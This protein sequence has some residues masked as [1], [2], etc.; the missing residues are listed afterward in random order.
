M[1]LAIEKQ[2]TRLQ[3]PMQQLGR[4]HELQTLYRLVY[5]VLLVDLFQDVGTDDGVQVCVHEVEDQINVAVI[6]S[7]NHIL[8]SDYVF[9][10]C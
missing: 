5:Y 1:A 2:I 7:S 10:A 4:V 8:K 3:I 9:M 6:F